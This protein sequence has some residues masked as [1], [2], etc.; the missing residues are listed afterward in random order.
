MS[1]L[2]MT[3]ASKEGADFLMKARKRKLSQ[4][5]AEVADANK[6]AKHPR[7]Q[8]IPM[9]PGG[10]SK[11]GNQ[12]IDE[13]WEP[14]APSLVEPGVKTLEDASCIFTTWLNG[15]DMD[16]F[17]GPWRNCNLITTSPFEARMKVASL[18]CAYDA[19]G[20]KLRS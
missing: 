6:S 15:G 20:Q 5:A 12:S 9:C 2:A 11:P 3:E 19:L 1:T 16:D 10:S 14:G 7:G 18:Q 13:Q 8:T 4:T 17:W